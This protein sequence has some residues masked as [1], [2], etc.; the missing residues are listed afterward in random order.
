[1]RFCGAILALP[2][3]KAPYGDADYAIMGTNP[4]PV[5]LPAP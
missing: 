1:M 5:R 2:T 4:V 3:L